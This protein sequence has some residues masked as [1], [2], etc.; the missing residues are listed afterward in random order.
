[1][2]EREGNWRSMDPDTAMRGVR[3]DMGRSDLIEVAYN[4]RCGAARRIA[5]VWL[6]DPSISASFAE[7]DPDP[8]VRR[9][10]V[11]TLCDRK[12][13]EHI[14]DSDGDA[15]VQEAAQKRLDELHESQPK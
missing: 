1:M 9:R 7:E 10:L 8:F 2:F 12:V 3:A 11:R 13:L 5:L 6:N 14:K 15:S 4:A